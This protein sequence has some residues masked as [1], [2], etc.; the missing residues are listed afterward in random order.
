MPVK[1]F[2][3]GLL[4]ALIVTSASATVNVP[5]KVQGV[6]YTPNISTKYDY[7]DPGDMPGDGEFTFDMI[8]SWTGEGANR[9]ALVIQWNNE[10]ETTA[11]VFGYRWDGQATG[12]DMMR[13]VPRPTP[14]CT[15]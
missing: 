1:K 4:T 8:E 5:R 3:T 12:A 13:A 2:V 15:P 11:L 14:A 6:A 7:V 9:A 10:T